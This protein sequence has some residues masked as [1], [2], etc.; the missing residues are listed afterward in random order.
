MISGKFS[1]FIQ[2]VLRTCLIALFGCSF[3]LGQTVSSWEDVPRTQE[4]R[5][6]VSQDYPQL[7]ESVTSDD[8][9]DLYKTKS[10]KDIKEEWAMELSAQQSFNAAFV[11][12]RVK[13]VLTTTLN[14]IKERT[15]V[16]LFIL[17]HSWRSSLL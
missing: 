2:S 13:T 1:N 3:F 9:D 5:R 8:W 11:P 10:T 15:V 6:D 16:S 4:F 14:S 7:F 17:H 12:A